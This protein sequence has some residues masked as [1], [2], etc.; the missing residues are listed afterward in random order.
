MTGNGFEIEVFVGGA[1]REVLNTIAGL[2][3]EVFREF[4]YL[5]DGTMESE[6]RYLSGFAEDEASI[7]VIAKVNGKVVGISTGAPLKSEDQAYRGPFQRHGYDLSKIFY[8]GESVVRKGYRGMGIGNRFMEE[9]EAHVR[10]LGRFDF[11][12]F[13]VVERP[14]NDYRRPQD[15]F[16]PEGLWDRWG[17][18]KHPELNT[19]FS[20]KEVG[21]EQ[22]TPKPMDFWLKYL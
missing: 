12:T 13:F 14:P 17:F 9:R 7:C 22:E 18:R 4:P 16:S 19:V 3:L 11:V 8:Y 2:R 6:E 5:Y 21:E 1:I 15:Y 20:W 10:R